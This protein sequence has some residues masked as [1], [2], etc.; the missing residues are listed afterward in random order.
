MRDLCSLQLISNC[1]TI[2]LSK[3]QSFRSRL[4]IPAEHVWRRALWIEQMSSRTKEEEDE[5][6]LVL[7][8]GKWQFILC[9]EGKT[10]NPNFR[11]SCN[12]SKE[13]TEIKRGEKK[14]YE[15]QIITNNWQLVCLWDCLFIYKNQRD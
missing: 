2:F 5:F 12:S 4:I 6:F 11:T 15:A 13:M 7:W 14:Y 1:N 3:N 8:V 10:Q 9:K